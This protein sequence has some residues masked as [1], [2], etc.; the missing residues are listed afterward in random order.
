MIFF[1]NEA[2]V[3]IYVYRFYLHISVYFNILVHVRFMAYCSVEA[4]GG[5]V[6][7]NERQKIRTFGG[8]R[9]TAVNPIYYFIHRLQICPFTSIT[10]VW[11]V[12]G[13]CKLDC[14]YLTVKC[15]WHWHYFL[16]RAFELTESLSNVSFMSHFLW[17]LMSEIWNQSRVLSDR[18]V[19][20]AGS[21]RKMNTHQHYAPALPFLEISLWWPA[22]CPS[23]SKW[24]SWSVK[25]P[26]IS[27]KIMPGD[28]Q[29]KRWNAYIFWTHK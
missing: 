9:V 27:R 29:C 18:L 7:S 19:T 4:P 24:M 26:R 14:I 17:H 1:L 6:F 12:I 21:V 25:C 11:N 13:A 22:Q 16:V 5:S 28:P 23:Y 2:C 8:I 15:T 10:Q 3:C 20:V